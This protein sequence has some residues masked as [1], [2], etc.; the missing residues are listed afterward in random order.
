[1]IAAMAADAPRR[2]SLRDHIQLLS[3]PYASTVDHPLVQDANQRFI[4][5]Q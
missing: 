4:E 1:M 2:D 5:Y 3:L